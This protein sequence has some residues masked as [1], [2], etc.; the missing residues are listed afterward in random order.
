[1][2]VVYGLVAVALVVLFAAGGCVSK[3]EF[4][5]CA[6]RNLTLQ[7]L[8]ASLEEAQENERIRADRLKAELDAIKA[9]GD[10]CAKKVAE[11]EAMMA[12][13]NAMIDKLT[14]M[15]S[16]SPL[17]PELSNALADWANQVGS[18]LVEYDEKTGVV[19]FKSDLLFEK[20]QA[21]VQAGVRPQLEKFA[22]I[23]GSAA[24]EGFDVLIVGHTD[25][26]PILKPETRAQHPTN[27]HLSAHRAIAVEDILAGAGMAETR[28]AVVGMGEFRPIAPNAGGNRGNALNRRVE[29]YIVP[30]GQIRISTG[31]AAAGG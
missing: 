7:E 27:W 14:K 25:D 26:V 11:L 13:K 2:K 17:P 6:R 31:T 4:D 16:E 3:A 1:M 28:L 20:G 23:M 9:G 10:L 15:V 30:A 5:K 12:E 19:R 8:V 18:D 24:A 22:Q 21:T 29:I